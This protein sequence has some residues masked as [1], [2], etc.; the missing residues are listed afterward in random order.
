MENLDLVPGCDASKCRFP[1][2]PWGIESGTGNLDFMIQILRLVISQSI[3]RWKL[4]AVSGGPPYP[5]PLDQA[6]HGTAVLEAI[7]T[8]SKTGEAVSL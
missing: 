1:R 3:A 7:V 6:V 4:R 2:N 5:L 8:S